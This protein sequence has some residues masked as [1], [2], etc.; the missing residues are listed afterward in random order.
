[1]AD[2]LISR[3]AVLDKA[4]YDSN[5][6][7]VVPVETIKKVPFFNAVVLPCKV[8]DTVYFQANYC[9]KAIHEAKI[10][11][12]RFRIDDKQSLF[13]ADVEFYIVDPYYNDGRLMLCG[14]V[15]GINNNFGNQPTAYLTREEAEKALG[16]R[17][18][19]NPCD[20]DEKEND[21]DAELQQLYARR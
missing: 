13:G 18:E 20:Q 2:E 1:M 8:G 16:E 9:G 11:C 12:L 15:V 6:R 5:F 14:A 21:E 3:E 19:E 7:L 4:E 10:K 17:K